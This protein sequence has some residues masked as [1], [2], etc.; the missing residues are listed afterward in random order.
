MRKS[1]LSL[2]MAVVLCLIPMMTSFAQ[3]ET[4]YIVDQTGSFQKSGRG[5]NEK[6]REVLSGMEWM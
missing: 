4:V 3:E 2:F 6:A 1:V 5:L